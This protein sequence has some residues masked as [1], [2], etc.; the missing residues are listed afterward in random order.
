MHT[1]LGIIWVECKYL[2]NLMDRPPI[3]W[4]GLR[5]YQKG[6][7]NKWTYDHTDHLTIDLELF[8]Y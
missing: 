7:N 4:V 6:S 2:I 8:A 3:M 5:W 1:N